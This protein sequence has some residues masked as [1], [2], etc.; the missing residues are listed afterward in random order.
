MNLARLR[1]T[2]TE[3]FSKGVLIAY[4]VVGELCR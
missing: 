2:D 3:K 1:Q 4:S